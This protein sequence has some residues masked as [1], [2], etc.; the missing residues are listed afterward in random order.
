MLDTVSGAVI[1][2]D[3]NCVFD[4]GKTLAVKERVPFRLTHNMVK[5]MGVTGY[6]GA[7]RRCCEVTMAVLRSE[8]ASLANVLET[9]IYDPLVEWDADR[10]Q[11]K[12][13]IALYMRSKDGTHHIDKVKRK[14]MGFSDNDQGLKRSPLSVEG[15]VWLQRSLPSV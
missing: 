2:V 3:F 15:Q 12:R 8:R 4:K 14:L 6:E 7:F 13:S 11:R 1:H 5:A 9:L 10:G